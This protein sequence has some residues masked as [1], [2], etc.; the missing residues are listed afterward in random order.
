MKPSRSAA[1]CHDEATRP[2]IRSGHTAP[3]LSPKQQPKRP[4]TKGKQPQPTAP[5]PPRSTE[6]A[7]RA[8]YPRLAP[9]ERNRTTA[10]QRLRRAEAELE[11]ARAALAE[12]EQECEE[13]S[14][15]LAQLERC[16][17]Q[18]DLPECVAL[19]ILGP[20]LG[21]RRGGLAAMV[22]RGFRA[23]VAKAVALGLYRREILGVS[24]G[25]DGDCATTVIWTEKKGVFSCGGG[26]SEED[27]LGLGHG[28]VSENVREPRRV[29]ALDGK[30]VVALSTD[31][32]G[33]AV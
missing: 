7:F 16:F 31:G 8:L 15:E 6:Q 3:T 21:R 2:S 12:A 27:R 20:L 24:C 4:K 1:F 33:T 11:A 30:S 14:A 28:A 9:A 13:P 23:T 26:E 5:P 32:L 10:R 18:R 19:D 25:G 22:C 29:E 17:R